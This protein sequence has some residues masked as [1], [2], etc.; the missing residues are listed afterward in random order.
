MFVC[1]L[2]ILSID[3]NLNFIVVV[4]LSIKFI[5]IGLILTNLID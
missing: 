1:G 5:N 4:D 2:T 3:I